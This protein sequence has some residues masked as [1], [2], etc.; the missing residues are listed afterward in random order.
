MSKKLSD[1]YQQLC[2]DEMEAEE[3]AL[4]ATAA[5]RARW[6]I[7]AGTAKGAPSVDALETEV[8]LWEL[9]TQFR[10]KRHAWVAKHSKRSMAPG[11][12]GNAGAARGAVMHARNQELR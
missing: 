9:V 8:D 2:V 6:H 3:C 10:H 4:R 11:T 7:D 5:I 1:E 12:N